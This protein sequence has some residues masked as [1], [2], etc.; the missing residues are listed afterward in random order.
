MLPLLTVWAQK[1]SSPAEKWDPYNYYQNRDP[2][3]PLDV[4]PY[5]WDEQPMV[6][7]WNDLQKSYTEALAR[8][9]GYRLL[10]LAYLE[11]VHGYSN[12]TLDPKT[13]LYKAFEM[14]R[15]KQ[16][17]YLTYWVTEL[18]GM[19]FFQ[20][21]YLD[22]RRGHAL[23]TDSIA[24]QRN[25]WPVLQLLADLNEKSFAEMKQL[26]SKYLQ[27]AYLKDETYG[28]LPYDVHA[29]AQTLKEAGAKP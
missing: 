29:K 20:F 13:M 19:I 3:K 11:Y 7:N 15:T 8:Q 5:K 4:A 1:M 21:E 2:L 10:Q 14:G 25:E 27:C 18:E 24:T 22:R 23:T 26:A 17:P 28:L 6:A 12:G 9:D 16:D